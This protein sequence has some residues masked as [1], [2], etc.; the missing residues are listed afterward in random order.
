MNL[1]RLSV[2]FAIAAFLFLVSMLIVCAYLVS[3]GLRRSQVKANFLLEGGLVDTN[4][5]ALVEMAGAQADLLSRI[6]GEVSDGAALSEHAGR[7]H[8]TEGSLAFL[9]DREGQVVGEP[10]A[11]ISVTGGAPALNMDPAGLAGAVRPGE[12]GFSVSGAGSQAVFLAFAPVAGTPWSLALAVPAADLAGRNRSLVNEIWFDA[13][14]TLRSTMLVMVLFLLAALAAT[15]F[16]IHRTVTQPV[17]ALVGGVQAVAAGR[18]DVQVP[19]RGQDELGL[20]ANSFN[21]MAAELRRRNAELVSANR[22]LR[23]A[24]TALKKSEEL[25][26]TLA[27]R[28]PN[29]AVLLFDPHLQVTLLDGAGLEDL[30]LVK[31][32]LEGR[33]CWNIFLPEIGESLLPRFQAA[34]AARSDALEIQYSGRVYQVFIQP[35]RND[36][37]VIFAGMA[38]F[39]DITERARARQLLE[40]RVAESTREIT[41]LYRQAEQRSRELEVL[42]TQA[43]QAATLEERQRLAREL[44]DSL[45]QSLYSL[46]LMAEAGRRFSVAGNPG[47]AAQLLQR[48]VETSQQALKEMRLLVY[49]LR[50]LALQ[51]VGL[52]TALQQRLDTVEKRAGMRTRLQIEDAPPLAAEL[53]EELYRIA[54]EALNN[55]LK[56]AAAASVTVQAA[57]VGDL[58]V[59]EIADDGRGFAPEEVTGGIGLSSM[60]ERA[61]RIGARLAVQSLPGEGTRVQVACPL[62]H[63]RGEAISGGD[64]TRR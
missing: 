20:L 24:N 35:A 21:G 37:G 11:A 30:G 33:S 56:H 51:K 41:E 47:G 1:N 5:W 27:R 40:Q 63:P 23:N 16:L 9:V 2:K 7:L 49:E 26:R 29:G 62:V 6:T 58:L 42:Y 32:D 55:S 13:E 52:F 8:P 3:A 59:L 38:I 34:L 17:N 31:E 43:A 61:E 25:Y 53:E 50:P 64:T 28:F 48:L 46:M 39:Q 60:R 12:Q 18:L 22:E 10:P 45:T 19:V 14:A 57:C 15:Q 54:Q 36:Q 4:R 44:H